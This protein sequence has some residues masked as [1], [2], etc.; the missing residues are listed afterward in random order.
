LAQRKRRSRQAKP[1]ID[2]VS[3][4]LFERWD[5]MKVRAEDPRWPRDEY[6]G[7]A[8]GLLD[9]VDRA[10]SDDVIAE[11]L[12]R[13]ESAWMGLEPPSPL[14]HRLAVVAELRAVIAA[15]RRHG[16]AG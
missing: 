9:L 13:L 6:E 12:A 8:A 11:H 5:P 16:M 2:A 3:S 7:Y 4:V 10:A 1:V 14:Q 15:V